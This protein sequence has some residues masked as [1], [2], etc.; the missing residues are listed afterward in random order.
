MMPN[1]LVSNGALALEALHYHHVRVEI[2]IGSPMKND[3]RVEA[4]SIP[5]IPYNFFSTLIIYGP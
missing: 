2:R 1:F 4:S 5:A 3:A